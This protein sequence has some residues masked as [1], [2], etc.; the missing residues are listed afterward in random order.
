MR[1]C[2]MLLCFMVSLAQALDSPIAF[3]P[4]IGSCAQALN[5]C[6]DY[7][8]TQKTDEIDRCTAKKAC[9]NRCNFKLIKSM[10]PEECYAQCDQIPCRS[11]A[12]CTMNCFEQTPEGICRQQCRNATTLCAQECP[13]AAASERYPCLNCC[14]SQREIC[15]KRCCQ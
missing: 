10:R 9:L 15:K 4:L 2:W 12:D 3:K 8:V 5:K 1:L 7:C 14:Y 13:S 11:V 6:F